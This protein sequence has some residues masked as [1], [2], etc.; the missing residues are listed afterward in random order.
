MTGVD[1]HQMG[2]LQRAVSYY[3]S[4]ELVEWRVSGGAQGVVV[5][6][7][8]RTSL[9]ASR[10]ARLMG[11]SELIG[12]GATR[13]F[14]G[15]VGE[16][17]Q[18]PAC[19]WRLYCLPSAQTPQ[20]RKIE[21]SLVLAARAREDPPRSRTPWRIVGPFCF[22]SGRGQRRDY[23]QVIHG[24]WQHRVPRDVSFGGFE[25]WPMRNLQSSESCSGPSTQ[26][27]IHASHWGTYG[28][29]DRR[30]GQRRPPARRGR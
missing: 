14:G 15:N 30:D 4:H 11:E 25:P 26:S 13:Q 22:R 21:T 17:P 19:Q 2:R 24:R 27:A 29:E 23:E 12:T 3:R 1:T 7:I 8:G 20:A 28:R 10:H 9:W 16:D 5:F 6:E 18:P